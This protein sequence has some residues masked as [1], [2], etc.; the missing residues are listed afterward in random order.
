MSHAVLIDATKSMLLF[1]TDLQPARLA[2]LASFPTIY[3]SD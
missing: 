3:E 2:S 1:C